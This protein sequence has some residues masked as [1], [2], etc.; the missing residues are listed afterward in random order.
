R[1]ALEQSAENEDGEEAV[2]ENPWLDLLRAMRT[3]AEEDLERATAARQ[4]L[5]E[6]QEPL[7]ERERQIPFTRKALEPLEEAVDEAEERLAEAQRELDRAT[8]KADWLRRG[9]ASDVTS[10]A[11]QQ[12]A[13]PPSRPSGPNRL[14]YVLGAVGAGAAIGYGLMVL[15]RR[16]DRPGVFR[17][18]DVMDLVPGAMIVR[19]PLLPDG[20]RRRWMTAV[21]FRDLA[22]GGW[23]VLC[24][25]LSALVFAA[26]SGWV[27][28]PT[29]FREVIGI[30]A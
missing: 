29:W 27:Q 15:R 25:G 4:A 9:D 1:A 16:F 18:E 22:L 12:P 8:E 14:L 30:S 28:V 24:L 10:Y 3:N 17:A 26:Y 19:V 23:V 7:L 13:V 20:R 5:L 2:G 21:P 11:I 6:R